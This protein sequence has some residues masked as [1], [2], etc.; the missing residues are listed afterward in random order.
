[1]SLEAG[2]VKTITLRVKA[3][4]FVASV[5]YVPF[6][7]DFS[8]HVINK[9]VKKKEKNIPHIPSKPS[10]RCWFYYVKCSEFSWPVPLNALLLLAQVKLG[11]DL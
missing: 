5:F 11:S 3:L 2:L 10:R 1:M 8:Q 4:T 9:I 6:T 7:G